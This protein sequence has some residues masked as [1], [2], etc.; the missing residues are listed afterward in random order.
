MKN[1]DVIFDNMDELFQIE[2]KYTDFLDAVEDYATHRLNDDRMSNIINFGLNVY[3]KFP[4]VKF[5]ALFL[6]NDENFEFNFSSS[7]PTIKTDAAEKIFQALVDNSTIGNCLRNAAITYYPNDNKNTY[8]NYYLA[9]PLI[10]TDGI[11]GIIMLNLNKSPNSLEHI[12]FKLCNM[13]SNLFASTLDANMKEMKLK[14][15]E[16]LLDQKVAFRTISLVESRK[17][18]EE[19]FESL[20]TD[21]SSSM[22][23]EVRTPIFAIIGFTDLL[24]RKYTKTDE[25]DT[26]D[27][28]R[29][30]KDSADRL[31]RLF[32][33]Y[34]FYSH[35]TILSTNYQELIK[36]R[37][38]K[39]LSAE[40]VIYEIAMNMSSMRNRTPDI[41]LNL[42][43]ASLAIAERYFHKLIE[44][45][46]DNCFKFSEPGTPVG[47]TS[48]VN[49]EMYEISFRDQGRGMT[50]DQIKNISAYKQFDRNLHEQQGSGLG[51]TIARK[52]ID[53]HEGQFDLESNLNEY[54][55][56]RISLP[57][58]IA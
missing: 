28:L 40:S 18:L 32:E 25:Q 8:K 54:T 15:A 50:D 51:T 36:A 6:M 16:Q 26:L 23:H 31:K 2:K 1:K 27:M 39:M 41:V 44:E 9:I 29:S 33:N 34:L 12:F 46:L 7:V 17:Q 10:S 45:I 3:C 35:L 19:E 57:L 37:T 22:P 24:I 56:F 52:I 53:I 30:V 21:L 43:D 49:N 47:I 20:R 55:E 48:R 5:A 38:Q 42:Q 4:D 11:L 14:K 58:Y 13:L